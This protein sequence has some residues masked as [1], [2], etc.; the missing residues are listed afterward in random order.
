MDGSCN[1]IWESF[2]GSDSPYAEQ[3][4]GVEFASWQFGLG[5][6]MAD[7]LLASVMEG[8]K[9]ATAGSLSAYEAEGEPVPEVGEF[10]VI[11]DGRGVG[12][13]IIRTSQVDIVPFDEVS[14]Q[15]AALEGDDDPGLE[16]W[17]RVHWE[18]F[19][20]EAEE[21]GSEEPRPDMLV[22]CERFEVVFPLEAAHR[23]SA[24][25]D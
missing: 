22:V 21:L 3:A 16:R 2:L 8:R 15:H 25:L 24:A 10:S 19:R 18:F 5:S 11:L 20:R 6:E 14:A 4:A 9:R 7:R 1:E 13:C 17:R 23:S 12:R